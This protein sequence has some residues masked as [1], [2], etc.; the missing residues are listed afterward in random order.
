MTWGFPGAARTYE[1]PSRP[2]STTE[3]RQDLA[4]PD[5]RFPPPW[6]VEDNGPVSSCG[7]TTGRRLRMS[8]MRTSPADDEARRIEVNK[9]NY[10]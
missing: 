6:T 3:A 4:K 1:A 10:G 9:E 8:T 2:A 7:T 5:R